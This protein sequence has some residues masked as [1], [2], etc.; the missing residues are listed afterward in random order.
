MLRF[1]QMEL[2]IGQ[3]SQLFQQANLHKLFQRAVIL[4]GL[5]SEFHL[6]TLMDRLHQQ[7]SLE[8]QESSSKD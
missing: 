2:E 8:S 6:F 5:S 4:D 1:D 3:Q 7:L